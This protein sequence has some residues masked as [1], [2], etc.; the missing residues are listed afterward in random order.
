[1]TPE[2]AEAV[3]G[4]MSLNYTKIEFRSGGS[5]PSAAGDGTTDARLMSSSELDTW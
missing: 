3:E 5:S 2:E 4:G 1:L